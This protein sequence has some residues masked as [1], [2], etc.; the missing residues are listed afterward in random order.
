M[1]NAPCNSDADQAEDT[2]FSETGRDL[3]EA[4]KRGANAQQHQRFRKAKEDSG[5]HMSYS[6]LFKDRPIRDEVGGSPAATAKPESP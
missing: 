1:H 4:G 5:E 6:I 2:E 3:Q